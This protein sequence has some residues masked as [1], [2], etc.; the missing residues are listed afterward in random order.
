[1]PYQAT[2]PHPAMMIRIANVN[3]AVSP[4]DMSSALAAGAAPVLCAVPAAARFGVWATQF[5]CKISQ[6][7]A[8]LCPLLSQVEEV[9][10]QRHG[11]YTLF[12]PR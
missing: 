6:S 11:W 7:Q 5:V 9:F 1:M 2:P 3:T 4:G 10:C 12:S 8:S